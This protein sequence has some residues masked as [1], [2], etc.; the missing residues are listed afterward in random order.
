[1]ERR[2]HS[3]GLIR[4]AII[5]FL[6]S[7]D[8]DATVAEV[9]EAV[10][11]VL[12]TVPASSVRSYLRLRPDIFLRARRGRYK[13][14][15]GQPTQELFPAESDEDTGPREFSYGRAHM[16]LRDCFKWLEDQA[17]E[18]IEAVVTDPPCGLVE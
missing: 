7:R 14:H 17:S 16:E 15:F 5:D 1:M 8:A 2:R 4:D 10:E 13:M 3:L 9:R 18:S 12:E 11:K 6:G